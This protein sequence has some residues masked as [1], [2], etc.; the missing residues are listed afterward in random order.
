MEKKRLANIELLRSVSMFMVIAIHLFTKTSVLWN[1]N[2]KRPVY[3]ISWLIYGFCMTGV[4]CYVIISGYF[5]CNSHFRLSKLFQIYIQVLFYSV[6]LAFISKYVL[7][8]EMVS[9]WIAVFLP[10]TNREYWFATIYIGMYCLMPFLNIL[11]RAMSQRQFQGLLAV[12]TGVLCFIPTFLHADGWL[13]DGGAY[14]ITWFIFL[15]LIGAYIKMYSQN[16][17]YQKIWLLYS[18]TILLIPTIKFIIMMI[19]SLQNYISIDKVQR[20]SEVFYAFNS[21]PALCA[22]VLLFLC[23]LQV[24][25]QHPKCVTCINLISRSTFGIYLIH[26]NRNIAHALW[27]GLKIDYW[28]TEKENILIVLFILCA[29]FIVCGWIETIRKRLFILLRIDRVINKAAE[30]AEQYGGKI[31]NTLCC[32]NNPSQK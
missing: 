3:L 4:N 27:E 13:G 1:M 24:K 8:L 18:G 5:L 26:N 22:S 23:F 2:P 7:G 32:Q 14:S 6:V 20:I 30:Q 25:I 29:V 21:V 15:Y 28:L 17:R 19:G 12:L 11:I 9:S 10:I 31:L 16:K